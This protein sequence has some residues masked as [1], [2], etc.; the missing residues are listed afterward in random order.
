MD[1]DEMRQGPRVGKG[2]QQ[3]QRADFASDL[4]YNLFLIGSVEVLSF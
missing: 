4:N 2:E 1:V 3:T